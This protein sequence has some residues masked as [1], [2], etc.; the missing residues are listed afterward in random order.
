MKNKII[1]S[2][3]ETVIEDVINFQTYYSTPKKGRGISKQPKRNAYKIQDGSYGGL[4]IDLPRLYNEMKLNVFEVENCCIRMPMLINH[5][6]I[7]S[8][9]DL[10][11]KQ[12]IQSTQ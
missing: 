3:G 5:S 4:V 8:Q 2:Y 7:F 1:N 12:N 6:S 9:K 10:I 11:Q